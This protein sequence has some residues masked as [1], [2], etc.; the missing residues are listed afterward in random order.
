MG[1]L[2]GCQLPPAGTDVA[3]ADFL[4][5]ARSSFAPKQNQFR[6][7]DA[8]GASG[9]TRGCVNPPVELEPDDDAI[10]DDLSAIALTLTIDEG[11]ARSRHGSESVRA[12]LSGVSMRALTRPKGER[13]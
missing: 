3:Q 11:D 5:S 1:F 10:A 6:I 8:F 12:L 4:G 9:Q 7:L 13:N 2:I